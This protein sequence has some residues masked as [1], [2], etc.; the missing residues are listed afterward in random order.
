MKSPWVAESS[1]TLFDRRSCCSRSPEGNRKT[2][3]FEGN[4]ISTPTNL[5]GPMK[6]KLHFITSRIE[7]FKES[8]RR[9][10]KSHAKCVPLAPARK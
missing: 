4:E 1:L 5:S 6:V 8:S 3:D 7:P 10:F 9:A 2:G